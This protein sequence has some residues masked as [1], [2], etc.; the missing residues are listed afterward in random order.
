MK[1][2]SQAETH[3]EM[4]QLVLPSHANNHGTLFGGQ[5]AAWIDTA[6]S[7]AAM[8]F[9]RGDV[10][11]ASMDELHFLHPVQRGMIV[12]LRAQVNQTWRSSMEIGVRAETEDPATGRRQVVSTA[13]LTFVALDADGRP[14]LLPTLLT[15]EEEDSQRRRRQADARRAHRLQVR[16]ARRRSP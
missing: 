6:A 15:E 10:V 16:E 11:T 2:V 13:Y 12:V 7:V 5:L 8:R 1:G 14:R 3:V 4:T 9:S